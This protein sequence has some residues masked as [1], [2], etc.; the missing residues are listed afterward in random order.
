EA[1]A[2][3]AGLP[4]SLAVGTKFIAVGNQHGVVLVFD[5]YEQ[6]KTALGGDGDGGGGGGTA[7]GSPMRR[8][9]SS[10]SSGDGGGAGYGG[11]VTSIDLAGRGDLLIAGYGG[12]TVVLWDVIKS[13]PLKVGD[14]TSDQEMRWLR[15]A[16]D[17]PSKFG[18]KGCSRM[19]SSGSIHPCPPFRAGDPSPARRRRETAQVLAIPRGVLEPPRRALSNRA[20]R[21]ASGPSPGELRSKIRQS[22]PSRSLS[23]RGLP[24]HPRDPRLA[25]FGTPPSEWDEK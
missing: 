23:K 16:Q 24:G 10:T 2:R 14:V 5:L 20:L 6:L 22:R 8:A 1:G 17:H 21:S 12:G 9:A 3:G 18:L 7:G 19:A 11:A 4:T 25:K 15:D 13:A